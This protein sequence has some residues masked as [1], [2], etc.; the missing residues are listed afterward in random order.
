MLKSLLVKWIVRLILLMIAGAGGYSVSRFGTD[1]A[2]PS[3]P[4]EVTAKPGRLAI[5]RAESAA[6]I[7][8]HACATPGPLDFLALDGGKTLVAVAPQPGR[9]ELIAWSAHGTE[10]TEAARCV[11]KVEAD[12]PP[13]PSDGFTVALQSAWAKETD[14]DRQRHRRQLAALY[15]VAASDTVGQPQLRTFGDLFATLK[16][17]AGAL[18]PEAALPAIRSAISD[19]LRRLLPADAAI[20]LDAAARARCAEAFQRVAAALES[21]N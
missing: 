9:Y 6:R 21:L 18:I 15:R 17:A 16:Q 19:E 13:A 1:G 8:W 12:V 2:A 14:P 3:V 7:V 11:L 10:P 4:T 5:I 20:I